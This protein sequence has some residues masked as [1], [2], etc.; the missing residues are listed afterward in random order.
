MSI[1]CE[2]TAKILSTGERHDDE[3]SSQQSITKLLAA[4]LSDLQC[5]RDAAE[6]L[7][8]KPIP[9]L[10]ARI[11]DEILHHEVTEEEL[12]TAANF[13]RFPYRPSDL[14]LKLFHNVL[15]TLKR[16]PSVGCVSPSLIGTSGVI[17]L[18]IIST[19]P[20][21]M[22]HYY[23]C[24]VHAQREVLLATNY[25]EK[26]V[27]VNI[28][29]K[30][31]RDLNKRA[32]IDG[33]MVIVK[34]MIDHPT[35]ENLLNFHSILPP[36]KWPDYDIPSPQEVPHLSMEVNNY[37]RMIMGTFHAKFMIVD[38]RL[39]LLNSNNIQDR[40]NL[41]MMSHFEGEIVH[42]F[43]DTYLISW[44]VP[45]QPNLVCLKMEDD[46]SHDDYQFGIKNTK[47]LSIQ[48][49]LK[50]AVAR[51]RLRL[52]YH[53]EGEEAPDV[54]L[55]R[56]N[57]S[58]RFSSVALQ[59][60]VQHRQSHS[61]SM[62]VKATNN[63]T[64]AVLG[65]DMNRR[66]DSPLTVHLN[67]SSQSALTTKSDGNLSDEELERL[68][69]DFC[70]FIFHRAHQPIPIALVNRPA[71]GT[72]G[73]IDT[74]NPQDAAW[75]GAFRH[76]KKSIFIQSPT[77]NASPA[78]EGIIDACRRGITVTIW[79][80]LGFNDLVEGFGTFQGGTN[81]YVIK[82]LYKKLRE[83]KD[84]AE[85]FLEVFWYTG[86]GTLKIFYGKFIRKEFI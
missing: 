24:I 40:P 54:Y 80:G 53:L 27:S 23:H 45:F 26:S 15:C 67:K 77:L 55:D 9:H 20:D 18:S 29:G 75:M 4:G 10:R 7:F 17:P 73:H 86:K 34:I 81:E 65:Y 78:I 51:A 70:P 19:I 32:E 35:K 12:N 56:R 44:W 46:H 68:T 79:L 71:R 84:G 21:I 58:D 14:F 6:R 85:K 36:D 69:F 37:H 13:G 31:L 72:P 61:P 62:L 42:S 57:S 33:R 38:R 64:G 48:E 30:A 83:G 49:P 76:A 1:I 59:A 43:Y 52:K 11:K 22:Q 8:A 50:Q 28:I 3:D 39:A 82:K 25:W 74:A 63:L 5:A 2:C 41:E 47:I 60:L 16:D 66:P